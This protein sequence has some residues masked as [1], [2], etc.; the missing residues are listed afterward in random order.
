MGRAQGQGSRAGRWHA[1]NRVA[2]TFCQ[3]QRAAELDQ[4]ARCLVQEAY[5][6][7][8]ED[9]QEGEDA[10]SNGKVGG[11]CPAEPRMG[12]GGKGPTPQRGSWCGV[13]QGARTLVVVVDVIGLASRGLLAGIGKG[14]KDD[15]GEDL[16]HGHRQPGRL[17][18]RLGRGHDGGLHTMP[19]RTNSRMRRMVAGRLTKATGSSGTP[20]RLGEVINSKQNDRNS[21]RLEGG[22]FSLPSGDARSC[23]VAPHDT[24]RGQW[25]GL[26]RHTPPTRAP[27]QRRA[28]QELPL[29]RPEEQI[30]NASGA[31][32]QS[33]PEEEYLFRCRQAFLVL[34]CV[35]CVFVFV[36]VFVLLVV[37]CHTG[38]HQS[39]GSNE[40]MA[41]VGGRRVCVCVCVCVCVWLAAS[42][43]DCSGKQRPAAVGDRPPGPCQFH[44]R[45]LR[46]AGRGA[47]LEFVG[48]GMRAGVARSS[49]MAFCTLH[50]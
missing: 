45:Q 31:G 21:P 42:S 41:Q 3:A 8:G 18:T 46:T 4:R 11:R 32:L 20:I 39:T 35:L 28:V 22:C 7:P 30:Y 19:L 34:F 37:I 48:D 12:K 24:T 50:L 1:Q 6:Q 44:Q 47:A 36:F 13:E 5:R 25:R 26:R 23:P 16:R 10:N 27:P 14:A 29:W 40:T 43:S 38:A 49:S 15:N 17:K 9:V 33:H 2:G